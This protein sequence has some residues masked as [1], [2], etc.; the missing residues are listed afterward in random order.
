[1]YTQLVW[2]KDQQICQP[3]SVT[4][5]KQP[6][7]CRKESKN[8][9]STTWLAVWPWPKISSIQ[10]SLF[11]FFFTSWLIEIYLVCKYQQMSTVT[12]T[13]FMKT[14]LFLS[15]TSHP[16]FSASGFLQNF[17][18]TFFSKVLDFIFL[19]L[20][21]KFDVIPAA[22]ITV[23]AMAPAFVSVSWCKQLTMHC[24]F[25]FSSFGT[26]TN[27]SPSCLQRSALLSP[28]S[29]RNRREWKVKGF[30]RQIQRTLIIS[31]KT[32]SVKHRLLAHA[33]VT[34]P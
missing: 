19:F 6:K 12:V 25:S 18:T 10:K 33:E 34:M 3:M 26:Q 15:Y 31:A 24:N 7:D 8:L 27:Q 2:C 9:W 20:K 30:S 1:M 29:S 16:I 13:S 21:Y 5:K 11:F 32:G 4:T 22:L 17:R 14:N 23:A 28:W